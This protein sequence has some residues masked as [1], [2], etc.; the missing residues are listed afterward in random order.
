MPKPPL[1]SGFATPAGGVI[2][3]TRIVNQMSSSLY[4]GNIF[5]N[6]SQFNIELEDPDDSLLSDGP[7]Y[8]QENGLCGAAAAGRLFFTAEPKDSLIKLEI[9]MH[10]SEPAIND[11]FDE[12]VE[13][14]FTRGPNEVYL[15]EWAHEEEHPLNIPEDDYRVRYSVK[16][17][18]LD[19]DYENMEEPDDED[20]VL[21]PFPGQEYLIQ[22]W[23]SF[24]Q[25]DKIIKKSSKLAEYWHNVVKKKNV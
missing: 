7:F 16:G 15:C 17:F 23:P 6:Y 1:R 14:S 5:T 9:E 20:E 25:E 21:P 13:V 19:Y 3:K 2:R 8:K 10:E 22:L 4:S 18:D 24:D 12:I 11:Q